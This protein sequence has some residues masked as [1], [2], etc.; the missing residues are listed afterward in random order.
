VEEMLK[1]NPNLT[2]EFEH[3]AINA[4]IQH[5]KPSFNEIHSV[6]VELGNK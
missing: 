3:C 1:F 4:K 5:L 6:V 2:V